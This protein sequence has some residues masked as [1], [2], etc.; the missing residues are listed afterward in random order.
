MNNGSLLIS[1]MG[2]CLSSEVPARF[3]MVEFD[4][5]GTAEVG[6]DLHDVILLLG[7]ELVFAVMDMVVGTHACALT[8]RPIIQACRRSLLEKFK[9]PFI[10]HIIAGI[11][12]VQR[13]LV[14]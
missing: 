10:S 8:T 12:F 5:I 2:D 3:V 1:T 9:N 7:R 6:E 14:M 13:G 4:A 11:A